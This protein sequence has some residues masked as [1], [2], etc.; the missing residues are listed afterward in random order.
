MSLNGRMEER[1]LVLA[2]TGR[3]SALVSGNLE[4]EGAPCAACANV[5]DLAA[6]MEQGARMAL[7]AEEALVGVSMQTRIRALERQPSWS[8]F[9][10]LFLT[11]NGRESSDTTT[12]ML[13]LFGDNATTPT[14]PFW[15]G[16]CACRRC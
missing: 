6:K 14:L 9:P 4:R 3:D 2:P 13:A 10:L 7:F 15:S 16:P 1:V 12:R 11:T 5:E 8:D